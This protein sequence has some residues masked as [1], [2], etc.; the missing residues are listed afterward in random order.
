MPLPRRPL[1]PIQIPKPRI[2]IHPQEIR[3]TIP[4]L[5]LSLPERNHAMYD[6]RQLPTGDET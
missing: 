6:T 3:N 2:I 5:I 4:I 1:L